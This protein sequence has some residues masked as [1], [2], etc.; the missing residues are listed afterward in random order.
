[1]KYSR[2]SRGGTTL[3][4]LVFLVMFVIIA[5]SLLQFIARQSKDA[6]DR[7]QRE[8]TFYFAE[9]AVR[10]LEWIMSA[11]GPG[12]APTDLVMPAAV[13][14]PLPGGS[15]ISRSTTRIST[16][17]QFVRDAT[18]AAIGEFFVT[19]T[20][21]DGNSLSLE[22]VAYPS[23]QT[24]RCR[25]HS[26]EL[27]R[28]LDDTY[29]VIRLEEQATR[30]CPSLVSNCAALPL[31][32]QGWNATHKVTSE[33]SSDDCSPTGATNPSGHPADLYS[34]RSNAND[35]VFIFVESTDFVP[36]VV[37]S[38][39]NG[40]SYTKQTC[41]GYTSAACFDSGGTFPRYQR[42]P[43]SGLYTLSIG[44]TDGSTGEYTLSFTAASALP[45]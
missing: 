14:S 27:H 4:V 6:T 37:L 33:L 41:Q 22:T 5:S 3:M 11:T 9:S 42:L 2:G 32:V 7:E 8:L 17:N 19:A 13:V 36:R 23:V 16:F 28:L 34:W 39:P 40:V 1:M 31:D 30:D 24:D 18:G 12:K 35:Q 44:S 15:G 29:T 20:G 43:V 45:N 38:Q 26:G 10:Y 25:S 21:I